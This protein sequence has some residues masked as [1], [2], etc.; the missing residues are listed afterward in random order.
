MGEVVYLPGAE[1]E[2]ESVPNTSGFYCC[3]HCAKDFFRVFEDGSVTCYSC[4]R[5]ITNL[6][7]K[8]TDGS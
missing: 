6:L 4:G 1:K 2:K 7:V 3:T 5:K 8:M